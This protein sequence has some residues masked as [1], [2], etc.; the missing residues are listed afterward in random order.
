MYLNN[1]WTKKDGGCLRSIHLDSGKDFLPEGEEPNYID[2]EPKGGSL[3]L[4]KSD[5]IPHGVLNTNAER[6]TYKY[7]QRSYKS[8]R[9]VALIWSQSFCMLWKSTQFDEK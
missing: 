7:F 3:V 1:Q 4:F 8:R 5:M 6:L 9:E 2:V